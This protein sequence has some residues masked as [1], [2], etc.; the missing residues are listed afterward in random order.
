[1]PRA[2]AKYLLL[3]KTSLSK[4][5]SLWQKLPGSV[6][7]QDFAGSVKIAVKATARE[8]PVAFTLSVAP[9]RGSR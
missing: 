4:A 8:R 6:K 5:F 1:M 2:L 9:V 7:R 3:A